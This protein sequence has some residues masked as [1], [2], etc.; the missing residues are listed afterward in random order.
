M[1]MAFPGPPC[2]LQSV[3]GAGHLNIGEDQ[4]HVVARPDN[5]QSFRAAPGLHHI[6]TGLPQ[7]GHRIDASQNLIFN[8]EHG[9][10]C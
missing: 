1:G 7:A 3:D 8:D 6:E 10:Q 2:E 4:I 5:R 9:L